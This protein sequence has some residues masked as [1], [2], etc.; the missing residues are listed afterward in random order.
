MGA[1]CVGRLGGF[2][3]FVAT[4]FLLSPNWAHPSSARAAGFPGGFSVLDGPL[5]RLG[6]SH[7][8]S[9]KLSF[10]KLP[11]GA[12]ALCRR[13]GRPAGHGGG[14]GG[15]SC[16]GPLAQNAKNAV[17]YGTGF[18]AKLLDPN[19]YLGPKSGGWPRG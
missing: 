7:F 3:T 12:P 4:L 9:P 11:K 10:A 6:P 2:R 1:A 8:A 19:T 15:V 5:G 17:L 16:V 13:A 14:R 18:W